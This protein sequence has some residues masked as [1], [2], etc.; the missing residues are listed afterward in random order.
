MGRLPPGIRVKCPTCGAPAGVQCRD[1]GKARRE[2]HP[3]RLK[4]GIAAEDAKVKKPRS[5]R[6]IPGGGFESNRRKH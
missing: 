1:G 5:V 2:G 4:L 6:T 3:T